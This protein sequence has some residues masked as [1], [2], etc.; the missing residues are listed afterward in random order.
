MIVALIV[1]LA[2]NL[3]LCS[4]Y[5]A[6][7]HR[8]RKPLP[9]PREDWWPSFERQFRDYAMRVAQERRQTS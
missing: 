7:T 1:A 6:R 2:L 4:V 3:A 8:R 9:Q 5:V